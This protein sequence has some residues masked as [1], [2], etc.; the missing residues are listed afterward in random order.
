MYNIQLQQ[1]LWNY[2]WYSWKS[3]VVILCKVGFFLVNMAISQ[4][5]QPTSCTDL[6]C[7]ISP[8]FEWR[9][10]TYKKWFIYDVIRSW[11]CNQLPWLKMKSSYFRYKCA[12]FNVNF[13]NDLRYIFY[14]KKLVI[15]LTWS[16]LCNSL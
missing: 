2:S 14:F 13:A 16:R 7:R 3:A 9:F 15:D 8:K 1:S 4:N 10:V 11:L 12:E 5:D 6:E